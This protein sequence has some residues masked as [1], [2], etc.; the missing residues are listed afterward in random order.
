MLNDLILPKFLTDKGPIMSIDVNEAAQSWKDRLTQDQPTQL[1]SAI[2]EISDEMRNLWNDTSS[3][4]KVGV[5]ALAAF[6]LG[7]Y[8]GTR[9]R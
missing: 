8:V 9:A 4:V 7:V 3:E 2:G 6:G 5:A 1:P